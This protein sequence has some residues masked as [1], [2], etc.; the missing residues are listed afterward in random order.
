MAPRTALVV[1]V[2]ALLLVA[3]APALSADGESLHV[4][5]S[6]DIPDRTV[7][8]DGTEFTVTAV[9]R[10]DPGDTIEVSAYAVD[11]YPYRVHVR[12]R[13]N[14]IVDSS[15]RYTANTTVEFDL[16]G[17]EAGT[18]V[19]GLHQDGRYRAIHPL[20]VRGYA[21]S[22][23]APGEASP[24]DSLEATVDAEH[25]R[26]NQ[27]DWV[28]VVVGNDSHAV[29]TN[30]TRQGG[31]YEATVPLDSFSS[32]TYAA[33]AVVRGE[34]EAF[35][36]PELLGVSDRSTVEVT[37]DGA[38]PTHGDATPTPT[39]DGTD[40][41]PGGSGPPAGDDT[42]TPSTTPT[43]TAGTGTAGTPTLTEPGAG[44][45]AATTTSEVL[46]PRPTTTPGSATT[47]GP[48]SG[49]TGLFGPGFGVA[50]ALVALAGVALLARRR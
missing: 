44:T 6:I 7:T 19:V 25:L 14:E 26:G 10:A 47:P 13:E 21:V 49:S 34:E 35:G 45:T 1:A 3:S 11:D 37:D 27:S 16:S 5:G 22:L 18:Y 30:A 23:D 20:V 28:Q 31:S 29:R 32:G 12:N 41:D 24:G 8:Y 2:T 46:T 42:E 40:G 33:Y 48:G 15:N 36:E 43:P 4:E 50:A 38:T 9:E 39:D 17:Y